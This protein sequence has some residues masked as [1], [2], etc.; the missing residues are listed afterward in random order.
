LG[1]FKKEK[2]KKQNGEKLA[3]KNKIKITGKRVFE[4]SA[5]D[6]TIG[7]RKRGWGDDSAN[8]TSSFVGVVSLGSLGR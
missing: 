6:V 4:D 5:S 2:E 7:G 1:L 8:G 3:T